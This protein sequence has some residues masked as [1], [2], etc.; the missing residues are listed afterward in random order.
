MTEVVV[1]TDDPLLAFDRV[2]KWY[3]HV[4]ALTDVSFGVGREI[5]GLV[6]RN[7]VGKSTLMKLSAGL[8]R[9]SQGR[10][11][12]CG[13]PA[14][15]AG[16]RCVVG[17]SPDV[18]RLF[19]ELTAVE[20][21]AWML[22]LHGWSIRA[23]RDR[24]REALSDLGLAPNMDR[25]VRELS[26]GMRQR[27]RLAQ[28]LAH[29]PRLV[30]LDEPM[31]GLDPVV[32]GE[33]ADTIRALPGRGVGVLVS[34]H[35]LPELESFVDRVVLVHQGR[36]LAQG[37]VAD[38]RE[39]VPSRPHRIRLRSATPRDLASRLVMWSQVGGVDVR[40]DAVDVDV[41]AEPGF[42]EALTQLGSAWQGAIQEIVPLDDDLASVFGYLV[43]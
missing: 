26:K 36:L 1:R 22:R 7:G 2:T 23:A 9:P 15:S 43:R 25:H 13:L 41:V 17:F 39:R 24:S 11:R 37:K 12:V 3:G 40:G 38:L 34:S 10:V 18:E 32:R 14:G 28:A 30:L 19:E 4:A 31:T 5:V 42:Y 6:G 33:F 29:S 21:V 8:L 35:V 20:F 16:A 27:V